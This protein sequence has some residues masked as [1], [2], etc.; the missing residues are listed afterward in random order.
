MVRL[1]GGYGGGSSVPGK[2][3]II[4]PDRSDTVRCRLFGRQLLAHLIHEQM[5]IQN[6]VEVPH[7]VAGVNTDHAVVHLAQGPAPLTLNAGGVTTVVATTRLVDHTDRPRMGMIPSNMP[8]QPIHQPLFIP[9]PQPQECLQRPRRYPG[10]QRD[11]LDALAMQLGHL[12]V[13]VDPQISPRITPPETIAELIQKPR[14][15]PPHLA[16]L[17]DIRADIL[18]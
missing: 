4:R 17:I 3:K 12:S 7:G 14:Q 8:L 11:W 1:S 6:A 2:K 5:T 10:P 9:L 16:N 18:Q 13:H 15:S